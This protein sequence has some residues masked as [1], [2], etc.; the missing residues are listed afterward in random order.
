MRKNTA[1]IEEGWYD[2]SSYIF[3][4]SLQDNFFELYDIG[5]WVQSP[6]SLNFT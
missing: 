6:Q 5:M 4:T 3:P 1:G 2:G